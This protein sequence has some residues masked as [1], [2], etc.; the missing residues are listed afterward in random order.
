MLHGS[1]VGIGGVE[2]F[3][4]GGGIPTTPFG[5]WSYD[6]TENEAAELLADAVGDVD[7]VSPRPGNH[8][9]RPCLSQT[10]TEGPAEHSGAADDDSN[11]AVE[12]EE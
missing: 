6:F 4:I 12:A 5:A 10:I 2:F 8:D 3:G 9:R 11:L 7:V 1:G